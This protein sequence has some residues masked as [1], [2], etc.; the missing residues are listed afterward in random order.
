M[1]TF[2]IISEHFPH[3]YVQHQLNIK[4]ESTGISMRTT[5]RQAIGDVTDEHIKAARTEKMGF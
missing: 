4:L 3:Q 2:K 5:K 1:T